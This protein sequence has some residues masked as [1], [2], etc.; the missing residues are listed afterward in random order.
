MRLTPYQSSP[1]DPMPDSMDRFVADTSK[2]ASKSLRYSEAEAVKHIDLAI[3]E[4]TE[5]MGWADESGGLADALT[6]LKGAKAD[7]TGEW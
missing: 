5:A 7:I 1:E 3:A 4:I 6:S 2:F